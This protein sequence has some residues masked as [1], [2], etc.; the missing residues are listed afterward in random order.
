MTAWERAQKAIQT[1]RGDV[2]AWPATARS[3]ALGLKT[4]PERQKDFQVGVAFRKGAA[5][6]GQPFVS[7]LES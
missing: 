5:G 6:V 2:K 3:F 4:S 1:G 7:N